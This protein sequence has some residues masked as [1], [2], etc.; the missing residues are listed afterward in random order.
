MY[1]H[2]KKML[3]TQK[4]GELNDYTNKGAT[5][6]WGWVFFAHFW[7]QIELKVTLKM[8]LVKQKEN[9]FARDFLKAK[10]N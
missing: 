4:G 9:I 5:L 6:I 3:R 10:T 1:K 7:G 2:K 8:S